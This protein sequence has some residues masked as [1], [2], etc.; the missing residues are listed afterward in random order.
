MST[1]LMPAVPVRLSRTTEGSSCNWRSPLVRT[2]G[3]PATLTT[4]SL[5]RF[6]IKEHQFATH[7]YSYWITVFHATAIGREE[8]LFTEVNAMNMGIEKTINITEVV[9]PTSIEDGKNLLWFPL[10]PIPE[11]KKTTIK[12]NTAPASATPS[13]FPVSFTR[14]SNPQ[15]INQPV[16]TKASSHKPNFLQSQ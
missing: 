7:M 6:I 4:H 2:R 12:A 1:I 15:D 13:H 11:Q 8:R 9:I 10:P 3:P 14:S 5:T 16:T